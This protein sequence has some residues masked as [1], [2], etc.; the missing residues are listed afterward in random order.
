M[1][2]TVHLVSMSYPLQEVT[3]TGAERHTCVA[4]SIG[5]SCA[6]QQGENSGE[7]PRGCASR[8]YAE[9][10][11]LNAAP[12]CQPISSCSIMAVSL[13]TRQERAGNA[14]RIAS[15]RIQVPLIIGSSRGTIQ[16]SISCSTVGHSALLSAVDLAC[17]N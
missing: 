15:K 4:V 11:V 8:K 3:I 17:H 16:V 2:I 7:R 5:I 14:H 9:E 6:L 12:W 10:V 13:S 1:L